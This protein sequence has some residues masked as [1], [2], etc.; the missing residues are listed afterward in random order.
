VC[1]AW[2]Q[3][4]IQDDAY[5]T[6]RYSKNLCSGLGPVWNPGQRIEGYTNFSWMLWISLAMSLGLTAES[7]SYL[8]GVGSFAVSLLL[9][10]RIGCIILPSRL[11]A[12]LATAFVGTNYSFLMYATGGLETQFNATLVLAGMLLSG[13]ALQAKA[14][15]T[16]EAVLAS[17]LMGLATMTRPDSALP[18]MIT[19]A[20]LAFVITRGKSNES[21]I[22]LLGAL[23][24]PG[25]LMVGGWLAWKY[26]YYGNLLPNTFYAKVAGSPWAR[27]QR[28]LAYVG[29]L[30]V[31]YWWLP[32][33]AGLVI[34]ARLRGRA[35]LKSVLLQPAVLP[36]LIFAPVWLA[37]VVWTGGDI[38]EFRQLVCVIP[39]ILL[40]LTVLAAHAV[41]DAHQGVVLGLLLLAGST[42][43]AIA[44]SRYVYPPG[45]GAIPALRQLGNEDP[46]INWR[47]A[48]LKLHDFLDADP[49]ITIA[50]SPAGAIPFF[51]GL[52]TIDVL[53]LNDAWVARHGQPRTLCKVC[54]GHFRLAQIEYLK[55]QRVNLLIAHPQWVN[56]STPVPDAGQVVR[57][58]YFDETLDYSNL[59]PE[60]R[61]V[62]IP[63]SRDTALAAV[64]LIPNARIDQ[65]IASGSWRA[66]SIP[67]IESMQSTPP[68]PSNK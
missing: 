37:Y 18:A 19:V 35:P 59:P 2:S 11:W 39:V 48:G 45:L 50:V 63:L 57:A 55:S 62:R 33:A 65:L 68:V 54:A 20:T 29:W 23:L 27:I 58:M 32:I 8:L 47:S 60:A 67:A 30:F 10:F 53:G 49:D 25:G 14:V 34:L 28:G 41:G 21:R 40:L 7:A 42:V 56:V 36:L 52:R 3:R 66:Q 16:G 22:R 31:S 44:F 1:I 6:F 17:V 5:I 61:L 13:R 38:M 51:S 24:V 12:L 26:S 15:G 46:S 64:Y 4:W 9:V 43:H